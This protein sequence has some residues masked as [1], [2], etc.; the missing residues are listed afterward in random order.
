MRHKNKKNN[1]GGWNGLGANDQ[2]GISALRSTV[3]GIQTPA[4]SEC[5]AEKQCFPAKDGGA[6]QRLAL[7]ALR[8]D[9]ELQ[10]DAA[11][12]FFKGLGIPPCYR[13]RLGGLS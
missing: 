3:L 13:R 8:W 11:S 10:G 7:G 9:D 1:V 12:V 2:T 5:C 4:V 6:K